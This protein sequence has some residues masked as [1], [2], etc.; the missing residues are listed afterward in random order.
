MAEGDT[1]APHK[2]AAA[3]AVIKTSAKPSRCESCMTDLRRKVHVQ[4]IGAMGGQRVCP[5]VDAPA[6]KT[7]QDGATFSSG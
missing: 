7:R 1:A 6:R 2:K 3:G 4:A 5:L